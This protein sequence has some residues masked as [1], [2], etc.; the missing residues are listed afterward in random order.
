[1]RSYLLRRLLLIPLTL[2]GVT[3][4]VFLLTRILPGGPLEQRMQKAMMAQDGHGSGKSMTTSTTLNETQLL[5]LKRS[6]LLDKKILPAF[7]MWWGFIP[8]EVMHRDVTGLAVLEKDGEPSE[9]EVFLPI[10]NPDGSLVSKKA[11]ISLNFKKELSIKMM[12]GSTPEGWR[13]REENVPKLDSDRGKNTV[14]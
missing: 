11:K 10:R 9:K 3:F 13:V 14:G 6:L 8:S 12:D 7:A 2:L 4:V 5:G 1:M